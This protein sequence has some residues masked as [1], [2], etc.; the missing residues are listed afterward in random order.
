MAKRITQLDGVRALAIAAVFIHHAFKAKLL[1]MGVDLFFILSGF[2]ITGILIE[3]KHK[4]LGL[5]FGHFYQRRVRRIIPAYLLLLVVTSILFGL[6]WMRHWYLY[7]FLMNFLVAFSIPYPTSLSVLWSLAVEEQFY[8][9]WP[10]VVYFLSEEM[11]VWAAGALVF[12]APVMRWELTP[13]FANHWAIYTLT[14]FRMDTLAMGA[15]I[16]IVW[17]RN[18]SLIERF[19]FFGPIFSVGALATLIVLSRTTHITT[20]GNTPQGNLW[21]FELTLLISLGIILWAL[22]GKAVAIL[23]LAPL[24]YLGRISYSVYLIHLTV[25]TVLEQHLSSRVSIATAAFA[26]SILYA[27]VSWFVMERPLLQQKPEPK[28]NLVPALKD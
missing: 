21:I 17:R 24:R 12:L 7:A 27:T 22:S 18:R 11:L 13:H 26:I 28:P 14:P 1:W 8:L 25:I 19:G 4:G 6:A 2:L 9:I 15:L 16:A 5:Y 20:T 23:N 10:F 3:A